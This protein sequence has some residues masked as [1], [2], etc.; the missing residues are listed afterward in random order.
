MRLS[1]VVPTL[2]ILMF[3][4]ACGGGSTGASNAGSP[5]ATPGGAVS[6]ADDGAASTASSGA[7][8]AVQTAEPSA[9]GGGGSGGGGT[10]AGVCELV[11]SEELASIFGVSSVKMTVISGPP[12]NCI[13]E[14]GDGDP[15]SAWSLMTAQ[16]GTV[17]GAMTT[18]PSTIEV[19]GIG[20]KAAIV[21]NTGLLVLKGDSLFSVTISGG[22][23]MSEEEAIEAS[24]KIA[25]FA[26][27]RL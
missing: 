16:A 27:G 10:A 23:D 9:A 14:S 8:S 13:V 4:A 26:A 24:K 2:A 12:D 15:L 18:D 22:A 25:A 19:P 3:V 20:D 1:R 11:T 7:S 5:A 6:S 21:Q 17:Y